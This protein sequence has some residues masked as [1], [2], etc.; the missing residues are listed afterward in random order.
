MIEVS[1]HVLLTSERQ[2]GPLPHAATLRLA[3]CLT[4]CIYCCDVM[5]L[6]SF[7]SSPGSQLVYA[8]PGHGAI[9]PDLVSMLTYQVINAIVSTTLNI[10]SIK[11]GNINQLANFAK[12]CW[13]FSNLLGL[14]AS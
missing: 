3:H 1:S 9:H 13:G 5:W 12:C 2:E 7:A 8:G 11:K 4:S 6:A 14:L 10:N